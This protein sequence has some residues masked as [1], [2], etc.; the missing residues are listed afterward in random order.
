LQPLDASDEEDF[1]KVKRL[2]RTLR[3]L[4][5]M[6]KEAGV[7]GIT[8]Q[9]SE[10]SL[11]ANMRVACD[12]YRAERLLT[13]HN[14]FETTA[15]QHADAEKRWRFRFRASLYCAMGA[16]LVLAALLLWEGSLSLWNEPDR[17][18]K[19]SHST[20]KHPF[21]IKALEALLIIAP[22]FA[23]YS[24]GVI[25]ILDSSRRATRYDEMR[26]YL[27]RLEDTLSHCSSNPSRLRI[28]EHAERLLIEEQHE[29]FSTTRYANV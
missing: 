25:T 5:A 17:S 11:E 4:R 18:T 28:I 27:E 6:D 14:Y 23:T 19:D 9:P 3:L 10:T 7:R 2:V 21:H 8:R 12:N 15:P 1:P 24:L 29:W 13:K 16:G 20:S 26:H 22:F